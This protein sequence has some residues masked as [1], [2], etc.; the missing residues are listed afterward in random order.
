[1]PG[2]SFTANP[3][4]ITQGQCTTFNWN[5]QGVQGVWF[6]P[7]GQPYQNYG[8]A[9][10]S[11]RQECP[12]QTTTY[13]L[14][15][16]FNDGTVQQPQITI[17]VNPAGPGGPAITRFTADPSQIT[18]GQAVNIQWE[19]SGPTT[20]VVILRQ[21]TPIWDGAPATGS[22]NDVPPSAGTVSY[23]IQAYNTDNQL[24]QAN[25]TVIVGSSG[26]QPPVINFFKVEPTVIAVGQCV[27]ISWDASGGTTHVQVYRD[28]NGRTPLAMN[29]TVVQGS[30]QDCP[31]A[32]AGQQVGY[33][34][35]AYSAGGQTVGVNVGVVVK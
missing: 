12:Q 14:R 19:V 33:G 1:V 25:R 28:Y 16:Q 26:S 3:T 5:V 11:S 2:I 27:V 30:M 13:V 8:V 29:T 23:G 22:L 4:T 21:G 9:G 10:V 31:P 34:I 15:V 32:T 17:T 35:E 20:R 24:V 6:F 7:Q 18:L